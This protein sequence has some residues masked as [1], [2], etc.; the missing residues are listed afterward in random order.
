MNDLYKQ[1]E[2]FRKLL[3]NFLGHNFVEYS[4]HGQVIQKNFDKPWVQ[5]ELV[6]TYSS[7]L[8]DGHTDESIPTGENRLSLLI[9][10]HVRSR[11]VNSF[12]SLSKAIELQALFSNQNFVTGLDVVGLGLRYPDI[13]E[14]E[15][16]IEC[17][18]IDFNGRFEND[19]WF[20]I[21]LNL[22]HKFTF[23]QLNSDWFNAVLVSV[24][25]D[26]LSELDLDDERMEGP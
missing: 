21:L 16:S 17:D 18:V 2:Y 6:R 4:L 24:D 13:S 20:P 22:A 15:S 25:I 8:I 19:D 12:E 14:G 3:T 9:N 11:N 7:S 26:G 23:N 5:L 1:L 10:A